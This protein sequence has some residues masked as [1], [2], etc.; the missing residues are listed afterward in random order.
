MHDP[1]NRQYVA[2]FILPLDFLGRINESVWFRITCVVLHSLIV[3]Y[4]KV[5]KKVLRMKVVFWGSEGAL[6]FEG[7]WGGVTEVLC[8]WDAV[9]GVSTHEEAPRQSTHLA[10]DVEAE[11]FSEGDAGIMENASCRILCFYF[12][13]AACRWN[14]AGV[15]S[16]HSQP[17]ALLRRQQWWC[18]HHIYNML[19]LILH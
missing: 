13:G 5:F 4:K 1:T 7:L 15:L 3:T 9:F 8:S 16:I 10:C 17:C 19:L 14:T 12:G 18:A 2:V 11:A 6:V